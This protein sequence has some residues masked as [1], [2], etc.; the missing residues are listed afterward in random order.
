MYQTSLIDK[1]QNEPLCQSAGPLRSI[2]TASLAGV[3]YWRP[4]LTNDQ[5]FLIATPI[6]L[7]LDFH[8][9]QLFFHPTPSPPIEIGL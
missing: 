1:H 9:L 3:K 6:S 8:V 7:R 5:V 2:W 4:L